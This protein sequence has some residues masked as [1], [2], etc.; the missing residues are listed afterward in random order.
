[1]NNRLMR[2]D[3]A[4]FADSYQPSCHQEF[5]SEE[6]VQEL[7]EESPWDV[8]A[9]YEPYREFDY[10]NAPPKHYEGC[11]EEVWVDASSDASNAEVVSQEVGEYESHAYDAYDYSYEY[12][13]G[14]YEGYEGCEEE[15]ALEQPSDEAVLEAAAEPVDEYEVYHHQSDLECTH[16]D[17]AC[18]IEA[19]ESDV[20]QES[21]EVTSEAV[22]EYNMVETYEYDYYEPYDASPV[23]EAAPER[24]AMPELAEFEEYD[25]Y[26]V[27]EYDNEPMREDVQAT[28][29]VVSES[30]DAEPASDLDEQYYGRYPYGYGYGYDYEYRSD[31]DAT[32]SYDSGDAHATIDAHIDFQRIADWRRQL[33]ESVSGSEIACVVRTSANELLH[34]VRAVVARIDM[35]QVR[36]ELSRS[37]MGMIQHSEQREAVL[38]DANVFLF[39]FDVE[40]PARLNM[41]ISLEAAAW[42]IEDELVGQTLDGEHDAAWVEPL[43]VDPVADLPTINLETLLQWANHTLGKVKTAWNA[44]SPELERMAAKSRATASSVE[45]ASLTQR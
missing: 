5:E 38:G 25:S 41:P 28:E 22:D 42:L 13:R 44:L 34:N 27:Y 2:D 24:D 15:A 3:D 26:D 43:S 8:S 31:N 19:T 40:D 12:D 7:T 30:A 18:Q 14:C 39:Q 36:T 4:D 21:G 6:V 11:E 17:D 32:E 29:E 35:D 37:V 9:D 1:M 16:K 45:Q 20:A 33:I 23:D 10:E